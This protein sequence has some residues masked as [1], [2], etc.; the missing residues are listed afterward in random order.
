MKTFGESLFAEVPLRN[1][2]SKLIQEN[3]IST[4]TVVLRKSCFQ[5]TGLFDEDLWSVEDRD[6]WLRFAVHF[7][8]ACLQKVV[9]KRQVHTNNITGQSELTVRSRIRVI[10]K[11]FR[12]FPCLA[13]T[14]LWHSELANLYCQFGYVL[15]EQ[16]ERRKALEAGFTSLNYAFRQI[17]KNRVLSSY[18]WTLG[19]GLIPASL[20][21]W[22]FSRVLFRPMKRLLAQKQAEK[23]TNLKCV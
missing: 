13:P 15:L 10:E 18:Q 22:R 14:K 12:N 3:F 6:L 9:C 16:G 20:L 1:A 23:S 4:P 7:K 19:I 8:L 21:G 17:I 11:N 5:T 2:F